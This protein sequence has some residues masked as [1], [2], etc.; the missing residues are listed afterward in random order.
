M[1]KKTLKDSASLLPSMRLMPEDE[2]LA[3]KIEKYGFGGDVAYLR[4]Y[5]TRIVLD[6]PWP[7]GSQKVGG[8]FGLFSQ[9]GTMLL[10]TDSV[11][12]VETYCYLHDLDEQTVH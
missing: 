2:G 10:F 9:D 6:M 3:A 8:K 1:D 11:A 7:F 5:D 4:Q 12:E